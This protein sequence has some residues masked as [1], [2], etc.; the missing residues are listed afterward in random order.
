MT[1]NSKQNSAGSVTKVPV[2]ILNLEL[3]GYWRAGIIE[4]KDHRL[5]KMEVDA[6]KERLAKESGRFGDRHC[7]LTV[8]GDKTRVDS[9]TES[10]KRCFLTEEEIKDWQSGAE[11]SDPWPKNVVKIMD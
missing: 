6:L 10:L 3:I 5:S 7:H 1:V 9:F 11:F 4:E 2:V 8:I